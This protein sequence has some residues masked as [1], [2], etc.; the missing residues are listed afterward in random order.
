MTNDRLAGSI[1]RLAINTNGPSV[2]HRRIRI[3][4][5]AEEAMQLHAYLRQGGRYYDRLKE[6]AVIVEPFPLI[7]SRLKDG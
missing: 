6:V 7:P 5:S 1:V 3:A 2:H 4:V